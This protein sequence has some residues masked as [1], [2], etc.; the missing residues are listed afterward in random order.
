[1]VRRQC[2]STVA[3]LLQTFPAVALLGPRQAGKTTLALDLIENNSNATYVDLENPADKLKVS[4]DPIDYFT[5]HAGELVVLDEIQRVPEL[6]PILRGVIDQQRRRK[7]STGQFLL[8]GSASLDL[9]KQSSESLAGRLAAFELTPFLVS[10]VE[11]D[12]HSI[13]ALW[14]RGGFPNS[15]LA[16][17][18]AASFRWRFAFIQT[19]LE[20]D[21]PALGPRIPAET[22]RR[23]WTMLAGAQGSILNHAIL[24][25]SLS[26]SG[27]TVTRYLDLLVDLLLVRRLQPWSG[28][29]MKR[30][31]RRPKVYVRD[32][33]LVHALLGLPAAEQILSNMISGPSWEGF[34]VENIL[35]AVPTGTQSFYYRTGAGAEIDLVLDF[36]SSAVASKDRERPWAIEIKRS[37]TPSVSRGFHIGCNDINAKRKFVVHPGAGRFSLGQEIEAIGLMDFIPELGSLGV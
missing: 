12:G 20:R 5:R 23:F 37:S 15:Y 35:N 18:D 16:T 21:I 6:F 25:L 30:L 17:D 10:E 8:L 32:S 22:L 26:I 31:T 9:L 24:A 7:R 29:V 4:S 19:Y 28:S 34:A 3:Q 11:A 27:Q 13:D 14:V 1:M 2:R 36:S 33:G